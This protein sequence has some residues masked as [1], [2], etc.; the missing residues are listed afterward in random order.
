MRSRRTFDPDSVY[1]MRDLIQTGDGVA[2][3]AK[4]FNVLPMTAC[5]LLPPLGLSQ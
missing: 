2:A 4:W 5:C 1:T 3:I